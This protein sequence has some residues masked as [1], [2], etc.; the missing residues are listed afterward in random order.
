MLTVLRRDD[1]N[2]CL[3]IIYCDKT[4][5]LQEM[6][7][8]PLVVCKP[9]FQYTGKLLSLLALLTPHYQ[10]FH[11]CAL[12]AESSCLETRI[13]PLPSLLNHPSLIPHT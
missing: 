4:M 1:T 3:K 6:H 13:N 12:S 7:L 11:S 10:G 9:H 2:F 8:V 5:N